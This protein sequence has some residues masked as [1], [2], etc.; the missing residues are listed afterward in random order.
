MAI[1]FPDVDLIL[2]R[3]DRPELWVHHVVLHEIGHLF[4][5]RSGGAGHIPESVAHMPGSVFTPAGLA[6]AL[7]FHR[8]HLSHPNEREAEEFAALVLA[9]RFGQ[10]RRSAAVQR[11]R[12]GFFRFSS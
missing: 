5:H 11:S 4:L 7:T 6:A 3:G 9:S 2:H 8:H 12:Y 10:R 1:G